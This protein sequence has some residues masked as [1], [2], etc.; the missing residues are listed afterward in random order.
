MV[1]HHYVAQEDNNQSRYRK[2]EGRWAERLRVGGLPGNDKSL[3][4]WMQTAHE[5]GEDSHEKGQKEPGWITDG[6]LFQQGRQ[7]KNDGKACSRGHCEKIARFGEAGRKGFLRPTDGSGVRKGN[8]RN[9]AKSGG[10]VHRSSRDHEQEGTLFV[11]KGIIV[12]RIQQ[13]G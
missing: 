1:R 3:C 10:G 11:N 9:A 8:N 13:L 5:R 12:T 6:E 4:H 2:E 7:K